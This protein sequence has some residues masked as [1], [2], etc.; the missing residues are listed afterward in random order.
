MSKKHI[1]HTLIIPT[2]NRP[3]KINRLLRYLDWQDV[4]FPIL[5]LDS[6]TDENADVT[7]A[8]AQQYEL[9]IRIIKYDP[10][11]PP[12]EKFMLGLNEVET[13]TCSF[14]ADDDLVFADAIE[15]CAEFLKNNS[16]FT[17]AHGFYLNFA[18]RGEII[19][20]QYMVQDS[21]SITD[22]EPLDRLWKYIS[23]YDVMIYSVV[24]TEVMQRIFAVMQGANTILSAELLSGGLAALSG[25]IARIPIAYCARSVGPSH[26]YS[27]WHPHQIL[28]QGVGTLMAE[29]HHYRNILLDQIELTHSLKQHSRDNLEN[30]CDLV[31]LRY[32]SP[33][34]AEDIL[35]F[36][37]TEMV[38]GEDSQSIT[39]AI[40]KRWVSSNRAVHPTMLYRHATEG[41]LENQLASSLSNK[42][43]NPYGESV[44]KERRDYLIESQTSG[45][46]PRV[47]KLYDEFVFP[48]SD[49]IISDK[50][51]QK[52]VRHFDSYH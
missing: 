16:D 39:N 24:R 49:T 2:Y 3:E 22:E 31:H 9:D 42:K 12:Y 30:I 11:I 47:Y 36:I 21:V 27:S 19:D 38:K 46:K 32:L 17:L 35:E 51:V 7:S 33:F 40:W 45:G 41:W 29:Y 15:H 10:S 44:Q 5:V 14:C 50:L 28:T 1:E 23:N 6:S 34:L 13:Q 26:F 8:L 43:S 20:I 4:S 52:I 37:Q 48:T 25:K 18:E